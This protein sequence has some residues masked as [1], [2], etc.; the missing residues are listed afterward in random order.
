MEMATVS[1]S[2]QLE[3]NSALAPPDSKGADLEMEAEVVGL[4][5]E[6]EPEEKP[7]LVTL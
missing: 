1:A 6:T 7:A 3:T 4:Q 5:A 2:P